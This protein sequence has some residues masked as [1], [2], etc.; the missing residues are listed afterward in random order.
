MIRIL[1]D[2]MSKK[3][4]GMGESA[5]MYIDICYLL[6]EDDVEFENIAVIALL[7]LG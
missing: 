3:K 2:H 6:L 5:L 7:I 4:I 1:S